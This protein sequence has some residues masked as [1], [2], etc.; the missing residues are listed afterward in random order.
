ML[1]M[2]EQR[3]DDVGQDVAGSMT[4]TGPAPSERSARMNS[5]LFIDRVAVRTSRA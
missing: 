5:E 2:I 4:R 1:A 3:A